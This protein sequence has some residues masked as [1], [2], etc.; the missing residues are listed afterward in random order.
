MPV[1]NF[2]TDNHRHYINKMKS[3]Q[4]N[5]QASKFIFSSQYQRGQIF[6]QL[7]KTLMI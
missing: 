6:E 5:F 3:L 1:I 7:K 2:V 4:D